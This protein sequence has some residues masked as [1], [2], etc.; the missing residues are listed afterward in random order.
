VQK[1]GYF[2]WHKDL[3]LDP[4]EAEIIN[5][6]ILFKTNPE[7]EEYKVD[8]TGFFDKLSDKDQIVVSNNEIYQN[9][10]YVTR[11]SQEVSGVCWYSDRRYIAYTYDGKLKII[12][13]DGTNEI[14]LLDKNSTSPVVFLSSGKYVIF[15]KD[16]KIYRAKIR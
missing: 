5:D 8:Q 9:S 14:S 2:T 13:I 12:E 6:V 3:V 7:I 16:S 10:N 4:G 1:D 15:E 11:F